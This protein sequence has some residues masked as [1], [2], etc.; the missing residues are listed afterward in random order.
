MIPKHLWAIALGTA[1]M[2][3]FALPIGGFAARAAAPV[4]ED[5]TIAAAGDI[6]C[7]ESPGSSH[8]TAD[9]DDVSTDGCQQN[10]TAALL[11]SKKY[12][13]ILPLGDEQYPDGSPAQFASSYAKSWGAVEAPVHPVP[14]NHEYHTPGAAGYY[15]FYKTAA[16]DPAKGYYSWD[17]PG[18]H[19]VAINA[20]CVAVGGCNKGSPEEVWL[21]ADLTA[22]PAACTLAYWHQPR[23]SSAHHHSDSTY[24]PFWEDLYAAKADVVLNGHDHDYERFA[25]QTPTGTSDPAFGVREFVVGTGGKSHYAFTTTEPN[26]EVRNNTSYGIL[27]MTLHPHAYDWN[28]LSTSRETGAFADHGSTA[29]H[30]RPV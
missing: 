12:S 29:C 20:N 5:R 17:L 9:K 26:S 16:G 13:A 25:L 22:H 23:F 30:G 19:F 24:Q 3:A 10:R 14:G 1:A 6:A 27:E 8:T 21:E 4:T 28:F 11:G 2:G 7:D 18:W 15:G